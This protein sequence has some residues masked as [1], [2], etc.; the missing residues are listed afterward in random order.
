MAKIS[1]FLAVGLLILGAALGASIKAT[2]TEYIAGHVLYRVVGGQIEYVLVQ[3]VDELDDWSVPKGKVQIKA[4]P[5]QIGLTLP[6]KS[7][8]CYLLPQVTLKL[9]KIQF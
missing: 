1:P 2:E 9:E 7:T 8:Y 4:Y 5:L 3:K 6:S